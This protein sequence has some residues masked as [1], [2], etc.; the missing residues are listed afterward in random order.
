M[1][2]KMPPFMRR[3][4]C[5]NST[6]WVADQLVRH[7]VVDRAVP[8]VQVLGESIKMANLLKLKVKV[9]VSAMEPIKRKVYMQVLAALNNDEKALMNFNGRT[10][11]PNYASPAGKL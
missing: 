6:R 7:N 8:A 3:D 1:K 10:E 9:Q 2:S 4:V 5:F 11:S